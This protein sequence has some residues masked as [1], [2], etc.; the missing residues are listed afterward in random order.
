METKLTKRL[1]QAIKK[2]YVAY[3]NNTLHP[4]CACN[5]AAGN[6]CDNRESWRH[7]TDLHGSLQLNYVGRVHQYLGRKINGYSPIELLKLEANFLK[8]SGY[9]LPLHYKNIKPEN[10]KD[11]EI[12]FNGLYAAISYLCELDNIENVMDV[13]KVFKVSKEEELLVSTLNAN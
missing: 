11:Q 4:E 6:V 13:M 10:P 5:C 7:F 1:E 8:G 3:T 2:L 9:Q 12:Q